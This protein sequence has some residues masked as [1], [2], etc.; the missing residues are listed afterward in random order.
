MKCIQSNR[1]R[2]KSG[3]CV[4]WL[5]LALLVL[6]PATRHVGADPG[7]PPPDPPLLAGGGD[8]IGSLPL[9]AQATPAFG[10]EGPASEV[11]ALV[12]STLSRS[13]RGSAIMVPADA[14]GELRVVFYGDVSLVLDRA[15]VT[16]TL[17]FFLEPGPAFAGGF[18]CLVLDGRRQGVLPLPTLGDADLPLPRLLRCGLLDLSTLDVH[19][20]SPGKVR[21]QLRIW[22]S[23]NDLHVR[24]R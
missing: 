20:Q 12:E 16:R 8:A 19:S 21:H 6:G 5:A 11:Q 15:L 13:L 18:A 14:A 4:A 22:A 24:T 7:D 1:R 9:T 17:R 2:G 10:V 3:T 23:G